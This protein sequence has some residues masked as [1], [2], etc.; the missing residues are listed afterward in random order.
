MPII[1]VYK[2]SQVQALEQATGLQARIINGKPQLVA[3][4]GAV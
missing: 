4:K 1:H 2:P 3:V